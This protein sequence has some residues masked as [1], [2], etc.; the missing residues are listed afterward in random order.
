M[1]DSLS[2][3]SSILCWISRKALTIV[4]KYAPQRRTC[5]VLGQPAR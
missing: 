3:K 1:L 2:Q 5:L 4:Q